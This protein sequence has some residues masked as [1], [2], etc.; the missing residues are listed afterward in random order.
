MKSETTPETRESRWRRLWREWGKPLLIAL[1]VL[2]TFRSAI[3]DWNDVPTGS[4]IPTILQGDRIV[5]N[6]V[7]YDLKLPFTSIR[8]AQWSA[9]VRG[10]VIVLYSP[11]DQT[12]LVKRVV[13]VPGDRLAMR[14][15]RLI[16]NGIVSEY[17]S[18]DTPNESLEKLGAEEG[19]THSVRV[20]RNSMM[21]TSFSEMIIPADHYFVMGDHRTNS[22][23]SRAFGP[24]ARDLIVG[25]AIAVALSLDPSAGYRPRW[26]RFFTRLP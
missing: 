4:M 20:D 23:D 25:Q 18:L 3:A 15:N 10:D 14:D 26:D 6:K 17:E 21:P 16:I 11:V 22:S 9:P 5:V 24:V 7:A 13:A 8:L 2:G 1:L 12:R 19:A